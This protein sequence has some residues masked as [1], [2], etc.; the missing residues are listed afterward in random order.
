M[1]LFH[2]ADLHVG[3]YR[4]VPDQ[5]ARCKEV[6]DAVVAKVVGHPDRLKILVLAGDLADR[7]NLTEEER[8]L[9]LDFVVNLLT[10]HVHVVVEN[11]NHDFMNEALTMLEPLRY[12]AKLSPYL[13]VVLGQPGRITI[14]DFGFGCVPCQQ[15][16]T[17]KQ[18]EGIARDLYKR[19]PCKTFYMVVHEAVY[20]STNFRTTW[21]AKSDKYLKIPNLSFVT[22]WMLG[23]IHQRQAIMPNAWYAGSP[24][25]IKADENPTS[26]ILE[27]IGSRPKFHPIT[28]RG[29]RITT[30]LRA[31][32]EY[33]KQGHYVRLKGEVPGGTELPTNIIT[34][35]EAAAIEIDLGMD[36]SGD[37]DEF[38]VELDLLTQLPAF[39]AKR[40]L[41]ARHQTMAVEL[42]SSISRNRSN[43]ATV[44][45]D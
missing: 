17:T 33:A 13:H 21:K 23:D 36:D 45:P 11:G 29:F 41:Q 40:G 7:K 10:A 14:G 2:A 25:Q 1:A 43:V 44:E 38:K 16:L 31:A 5:L 15:D 30:D 6:L 8:N 12:L 4:F 28:S 24:L 9:I 3:A 39:L 22:G 26:G 34:D 35:G 20:G 37:V 19:A 18:L 27:W 32:L 42:V